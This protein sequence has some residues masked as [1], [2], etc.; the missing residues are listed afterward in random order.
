MKIKFLGH[1]AFLLTSD[2]GVR[3]ITDPYKPGCFDGGIQYAAIDEPADMVTISHDH[4][5]HNETKINGNPIFV[6]K[7]GTNEIKGV[8]INGIESYHDTNQGKDRGR[9]II[10][11]L[12][13]DGLRVVHLGDLGHELSAADAKKI[14]KVDVLLVPVGGFFTIDSSTADK[15]IEMLSPKIVIPMHYKTPKC[16]FPIATLDVFLKGKEALNKGDEIEIK[17]VDIKENMQI[18]VLDPVK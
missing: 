18:I 3:V 4:D 5:D 16:R 1:A 12:L 14:G 6:R 2:S 10:F 17:T 15:M 9:N 13:I 8:M 11:N 7:P